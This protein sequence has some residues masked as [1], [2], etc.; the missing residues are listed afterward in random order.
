MERS[1]FSYVWKYSRR[2][3]FVLLALTL[4][5]FPVLYATLE[6][7]KRIINDA[8]EAEPGTVMVWGFSLNRIE[9]LLALCVAFLAAVIL[10]GLVKMRLNTMKGILA[11]RLLRRFRYTLIQ[12]MLRFP[13][14]HF[15]RLSQGEMVSIV[16][17]ETEPLGGIMGDALAQPVFQAG[18]MVTILSFLFLQNVWLGLTAIALIPLQAWLIPKLQRQ[19]NLLNKE[20]VKEVR[21]F[22]ERIGETVAGA[23]DIRANGVFAFTMAQFTDGL[24]RLFDI[25]YRIYQK[26]YFMKFVNN[27]ITQLT[28]FFFFSIGGYLV[29]EGRLSLGALVAALAAYKDLS[30]PWKELLAYY[31]QS[32]DMSLRYTTIVE[33]FDPPGL[34][35]SKLIEGQPESYPHLADDIVFDNVTV[36]DADGGVVL[37]RLSMTIPGGSNVALS[38]ATA[39]E[40]AA[41]S[42]LLSR[43]I[44]PSNGRIMIGEQDMAALHQGVIGARIGIAD[45]KPYLF[46]G[47]LKDNTR[48]ALR[49]SPPPHD[50]TDKQIGVALSEAKRTGNS[51]ERIDQPW[52]SLEQG[53]FSSEEDLFQWWRRITEV[54]GTDDWLFNRGLAFTFAPESHE[55]LAAQI[56]ALRP[57]AAKRFEEAGVGDA[58][59]RF[60]RE[61]FNPGQAIGGNLLY[62]ASKK[63]LNP[64]DLAEDEG[65]AG[66]LDRTGLRQEALDLGADLLSVIAVTFGDTDG[67]HPLLRR[68]GLEPE[69]FAWLTRIDERREA[70]GVE[71]LCDLDSLLLCALPFC[72]RSEQVGS[73]F[74]DGLKED[75]L[76]V[77]RSRSV[78]LDDWGMTRFSPIDPDKFI[79]GITV[80]ENLFFGKLS[81]NAGVGEDR[82]NQLAKEV[83]EEAGLRN[84]V[85][86]LIWDMQVTLGG[87][88]LSTLTHERIAF[89]RATMKRPDILLLDHALTSHEPAD[90]IETRAKLR[91]L[92]PESTL[93]HLEPRLEPHEE[94]DQVFEIVNGRLAG[95]EDLPDDKSIVNQTDMDR[96][97]KALGNTS[98]FG[99]LS[100]PQLR[101]LAFA[102]VWFRVPEGSY[103]FR[104][105]D[106][107]DAAYL[108]TEG[109][110]EL[111]WSDVDNLEFEERFVRPGRLIGDLSVI[112]NERRHLDLIAREDV[113]GLRI[114]ATE[115]RDVIAHDPEIAASLLQTVSGYLIG[116]AQQLRDVKRQAQ[117]RDDTG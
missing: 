87:S 3:Q 1:L 60:D 32:Q 57:I 47:S 74:P 108:V 24:G 49:L 17:S 20:R 114:G 46:K 19:V 98:L 26:K 2:D 102:S 77:R 54:L 52:L 86:A 30:A 113:S 39:S 69:L 83:L 68:L 31:N 78:E 62:A 59:H 109:V 13:M 36:N 44:M 51:V 25:R 117:Q 81:R 21:Q 76:A 12:R 80:L 37:D 99:Q 4:L 14:L 6:L 64:L 110:A 112:R 100:R 8:I 63:R 34:L 10:W 67:S 42:Q 96:K 116:T 35:D 84:R 85:A 33:H 15:R 58:F 61:A 55:D 82:L 115:L 106:E 48:L 73:D 88:N 107:A 11:E 70:G 90:R 97:V 92:L 95:A 18:Q 65:F 43:S 93:I 40:R 91:D 45:T 22:S 50:E 56:V 9:Y 5:T 41:F 66:F 103:I 75:I 94:F 89:I 104:E 23:G 53:G 27:L 105:G 111:Y 71:S 29:I 7:P 16:T 79:E 38:I 101:I 28:P 72:F